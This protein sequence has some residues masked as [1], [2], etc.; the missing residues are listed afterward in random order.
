M[1]ETRTAAAYALAGSRCAPVGSTRM[2]TIWPSTSSRREGDRAKLTIEPHA[3]IPRTARAAIEEEGKRT[4]RI[5]EPDASVDVV[6][7]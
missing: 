2:C 1:A 7:V 3:D 4:A 6:G 5:C